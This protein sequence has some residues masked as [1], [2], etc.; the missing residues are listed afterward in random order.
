M[1]YGVEVCSSQECD[2]AALSHVQVFSPLS[3]VPLLS[4]YYF[5]YYSRELQV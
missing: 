1:E 3:S 4:D 5:Y 2:S